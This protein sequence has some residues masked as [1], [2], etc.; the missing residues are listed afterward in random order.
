M[1]FVFYDTETT[2]ANTSFD[3][4]LQFAAIKT[5]NELNV[6]DQF[7]IRCRIL[8]HVIP[9][10]A[11]MRVTGVTAE[12]L[13]DQRLPSHYEMACAIRE[14]M[15]A[16]S[17][18]IFIGY[19][20]IEFDEHLFRQM[21][22]KTLHP[23]YLTNSPGNA[24]SD[25]LRMMQA[26]HLFSPQALTFPL[27]DKGLPILKLERVAP[28]N[29]FN[30]ANAHDALADVHATIHMSRLVRDK[31]PD[32][33]SSF[34]RFCHKAAVL[35]YIGDERVFCLSEFY[36]GRPY[37][38]PVTILGVSKDI[39]SEAYAFDLSNDPDELAALS[40][41]NLVARLGR[42]P[43]IIRKLRANAAPIIMP[44]DD[45]PAICKFHAVGADEIERRADRL[46]DDPQLRA[47]LVACFLA[48]AEER[49]ASEHVEKQLYDGFFSAADQR[50]MGQFHTLPW[51]DRVHLVEEFEDPRLR[52]IGRILIHCEAPGVLADEMAFAVELAH[53]IRM[54]NQEDECEW[55][56]IALALRDLENEAA[57]GIGTAEFWQAH[58]EYLIA[59][60]ERATKWRDMSG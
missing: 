8:P 48:S 39:P 11:A 2:G 19:N 10:P 4:I 24:R 41:Q 47:Y 6:I 5:D 9:H 25:V 45:A 43:K 16:W 59:C 57:S 49:E 52:S 23:P 17:P 35:D 60:A 20:S 22:Y 51:Q 13:V 14:K 31:A 46:A 50:R 21:F 18:A 55:T 32:V 34:M 42:S 58:R 56:S 33:W 29:G 15:T 28:L 27:N 36:F 1:S 44:I 54:L 38:W 3:Q 26:V 40:E 7:E 37:S 12:M 53:S 30:H